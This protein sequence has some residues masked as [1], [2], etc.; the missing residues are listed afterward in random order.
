[1]VS[2]IARLGGEPTNRLRADLANRGIQ[3]GHARALELVAHQY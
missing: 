1:M 3:I 2:L